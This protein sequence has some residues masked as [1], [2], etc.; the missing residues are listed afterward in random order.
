MWRL[1]LRLV[2]VVLLYCFVNGEFR[3]CRK[4]LLGGY[5]CTEMC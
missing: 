4:S 2:V 1:L 5:K 3:N